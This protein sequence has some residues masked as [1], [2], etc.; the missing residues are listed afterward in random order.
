[1]SN[2]SNSSSS[3]SGR[4]I[5]CLGASVTVE[6]A[7]G[8]VIL[9]HLRKNQKMIA[10][11]DQVK[12]ERVDAEAG[13]ITAIEPRRSLLARAGRHGVLKPMAANI[14]VVFIV[15]APPPILSEY[16]VDCYLL[17]AEL[18]KLKAVIVLNKADL[19]TDALRKEVEARLHPYTLL[20]YPV[21]LTSCVTQEGWPALLDLLR[22]QTGVLI[23]PSGVGKS[24]L[25]AKLSTDDS[26]RVGVVTAKGGGK[27]TTTVSRLYHLPEG[28]CLID[29]PGIREFDLWPVTEEEIRRGFREF[30][31]ER[32]ACKFRDCRHI[33]EPECTLR[34]AVEE[35][36][37]SP[38]RYAHYQLLMKKRQP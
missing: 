37:M 12:W 35:G 2:F 4:V 14:D 9:C 28:G 33:S 18:L 25:I 6:A 32:A 36:K 27:H 5:A 21:L 16:L 3:C 24:S 26:I 19:L 7:D 11:G 38:L 22:H 31:M 20:S 10:T 13:V 8:Q 17:A 29:S 34:Q 30:R 23:G 1:M 15:M